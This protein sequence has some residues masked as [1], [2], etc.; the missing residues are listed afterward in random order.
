MSFSF[1]ESLQFGDISLACVSSPDVSR[2]L[3]IS[4]LDCVSTLRS[5]TSVDSLLAYVV[6]FTATSPVHDFSFDIVFHD[7]TAK[8]CAESGEHLEA[9]SWEYANGF[10][11]IGT[12][13][14][15]VL[16]SR[17]P[18]IETAACEK[19]YPVEYL[20]N[21]FRLSLPYVPPN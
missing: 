3:N 13:D 17:M 8:G 4:R 6:E 19:D 10:L 11:M 2:R 20:S 14:G 9:Q 12:E 16:H 7:C 18:W 21:G 5:D 1:S 15:E